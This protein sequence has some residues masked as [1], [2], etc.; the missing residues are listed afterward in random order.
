MLSFLEGKLYSIDDKAIFDFDKIEEF[1]SA[2]GLPKLYVGG[3]FLAGKYRETDYSQ[4]LYGF[5]F[6]IGIPI[7]KIV[8]A[9]CYVDFDFHRPGLAAENYWKHYYGLRA[10]VP[11]SLRGYRI[12]SGGGRIRFVFLKHLE[13]FFGGGIGTWGFSLSVNNID[14]GRYSLNLYEAEVGTG[15]TKEINEKWFI[16]GRVTYKNYFIDAVENH[17]MA[18]VFGVSAAYR[19][20][21]KGY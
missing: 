9:E 13:F 14:Y 4:M 12:L 18:M 8:S 20:F 5:N 6:I 3:G 11:L 16:S 15:F 7:D 21:R 10:V 17:E 1:D 2:R 19:W